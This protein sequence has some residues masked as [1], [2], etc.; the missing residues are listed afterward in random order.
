M[1][2][3]NIETNFNLSNEEKEQDIKLNMFIKRLDS[4]YKMN[5]FSLTFIDKEIENEYQ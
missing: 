3:S 4:K 2:H 1:S 5:P